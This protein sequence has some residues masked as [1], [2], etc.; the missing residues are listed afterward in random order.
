[1]RGR[2][3]RHDEKNDVVIVAKADGGISQT[4]D[5]REEFGWLHVDEWGMTFPLID[6]VP[7]YAFTREGHA[8]IQS[9]SAYFFADET[10][11]PFTLDRLMH[12]G[13]EEAY[14]T[15]A[16]G[17]SVRQRKDDQ[18][19][20]R[21]NWVCALAGIALLAGALFW[22]I[23]RSDDPVIVVQQPAPVVQDVGPQLVTPAP[24][25]SPEVER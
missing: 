8:V 22:T 10:P 6:P 18:S 9:Y 17:R 16:N 1:M 7:V 4:K 20:I 21:L 3:E 15:A 11:S 12:T 2:T 23:A 25:Q 14:R 13:L 24:P 19:R 5:V